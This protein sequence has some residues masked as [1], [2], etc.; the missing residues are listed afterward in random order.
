MTINSNEWGKLASR[1][2]KVELKKKEMTYKQLAA[3]LCELNI[4]YQESDIS[5]R[6]S[7]A[8]FSAAFFLQCLTALDIKALQLED[9]NCSSVHR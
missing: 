2:I 1:I 9:L 8:N 7:R 3:K 6:L 5:G 4:E